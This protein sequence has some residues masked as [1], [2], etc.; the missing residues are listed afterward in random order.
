[1]PACTTSNLIPK[2]MCYYD[3]VATTHP[4][5]FQPVSAPS[6][7]G[8]GIVPLSFLKQSPGGHEFSAQPRGSILPG[9][10]RIL[11]AP[12][13]FGVRSSRWNTC[14]DQPT[15]LYRLSRRALSAEAQPR[16]RSPQSELILFVLLSKIPEVFSGGYIRSGS[17]GRRFSPKQ[18]PIPC[19]ERRRGINQQSAILPYFSHSGN[20]FK[21]HLV[22]YTPKNELPAVTGTIT[23][24]ARQSSG[25]APN[26][27]RRGVYRASSCK[28]TAAS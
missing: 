24:H 17:F 28:P 8:E 15:I 21:I 9:P 10:I 12:V 11:P 22:M 26:S 1:M 5:S 23:A 20:S 27:P 13:F 19:P 18:S 25:M 7:R 14:L 2:I 6:C 3:I 16:Q 4:P